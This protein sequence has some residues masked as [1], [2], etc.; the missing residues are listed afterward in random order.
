MPLTDICIP[1]HDALDYTK[2]CVT[3]IYDHTPKDQFRLVLVDDYSDQP[4]REYLYGPECLGRDQRNVYVR[5]GKQHWFTRASNTGLK[6]VKTSKAILLNSDCVVN[7]G[8]MDE[9]YSVMDAAQNSL[10]KTVALVGDAGRDDGKRWEETIPPNYVTG[11]C[12]LLDM[13]C[14]RRVA[15]ERGTPDRYLDEI[16]Q[17]AIHINSD[18]YL[19]IELNKLGYATVAAFQVALGHHGGKSWG[20]ELTKV[21][22]I[23]LADV[24]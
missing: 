20:Y 1:V 2:A 15:N 14:L 3:S 16:H 4:T 19:S 9:L 10:G 18:R 24:D 6:L 22:K 11:H 17:E 13:D 5:L 12:L 7:D 8:W 21:G 23:Q